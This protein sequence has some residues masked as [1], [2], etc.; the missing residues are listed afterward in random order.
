MSTAEEAA[1]CVYGALAT[2]KVVLLVV[3]QPEIAARR[4][5]EE[6][7]TTVLPKTTVGEPNDNKI[8]VKPDALFG[9][10][11]SVFIAI[12][13]YIGIMCLYNTHTPVVFPRKP[14]VFGREL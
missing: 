7:E 6:T 10:A 12:I 8:Y 1:K 9:I 3:K 5:L 13:T 11:L 4:V 14:F 2:V